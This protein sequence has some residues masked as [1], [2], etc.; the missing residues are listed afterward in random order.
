MLTAL[1]SVVLDV[2]DF[3]AAVRDYA[4]LLGGAPTFADRDPRC[5]LRIAR[6]RVS[7]STLE[8]RAMADR[9]PDTPGVD[10]IPL[11]D[12]EGIAGLRLAGSF[13]P[14]ARLR[15]GPVPRESVPIELVVEQPVCGTPDLASRVPDPA[16]LPDSAEAQAGRIEG[17]DHVV[18]ASPDPERTRHHLAEDLGLRLALDRRFPER[19]LRLLFFRLGGVTLEVAASLAERPAGTGA[20][21]RVDA[22]HGLAWRVPRL[23]AAHARLRAAG[24]AI[25]DV[26]AGHKAGTRVA[27]LRAPLCGVPILLIEPSP[28]S[29]PGSGASSG[30][31]TPPAAGW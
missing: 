11:R 3:E 25:S 10:G 7:N 12:D 30:A 14:G 26:R 28:R 8:L 27:S 29:A 4:L 21:A 13:G 2:A 15:P 17:L 31:G 18:I 5:G 22:F 19:G 20:V 24:V 23:E 1:E 16:G 6:F 9:T